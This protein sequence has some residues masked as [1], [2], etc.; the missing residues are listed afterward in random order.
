MSRIV[1]I[2]LMRAFHADSIPCRACV[3]WPWVALAVICMLPVKRVE[4]VCTDLLRVGIHVTVIALLFPHSAPHA[5][6]CSV[7]ALMY[8]SWAMCRDD[9]SSCIQCLFVVLSMSWVA[10]T[11]PHAVSLETQLD[12]LLIPDVVEYVGG[13]VRQF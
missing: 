3:F 6:A 11:C 1:Y 10:H 8:S 7:N 5:F 4:F 2:L 12:A 13:L 9:V